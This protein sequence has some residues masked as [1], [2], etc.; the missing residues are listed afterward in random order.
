MEGT[1]GE[2]RAVEGERTFIIIKSNYYYCT[3]YYLLYVI[4]SV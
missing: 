3:T 2:R 4:I 1:E